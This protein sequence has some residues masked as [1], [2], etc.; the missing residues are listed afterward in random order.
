MSLRTSL[1]TRKCQAKAV[2]RW[3]LFAVLVH[4]RFLHRSGVARLGREG[5]RVLHFLLIVTA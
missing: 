1:M 3:V 4:W 5:G 2:S